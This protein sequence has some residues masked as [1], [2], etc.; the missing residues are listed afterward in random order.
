MDEW[1]VFIRENYFKPRL[2][3][4]SLDILG[5]MNSY[6]LIPHFIAFLFMSTGNLALPSL[7]HKLWVW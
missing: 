2:L 3:D 6:G 7:S 5:E 4:F 1:Y